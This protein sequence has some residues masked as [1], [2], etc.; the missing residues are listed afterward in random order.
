MLHQTKL[1]NNLPFNIRAIELFYRRDS[2]LL[3]GTNNCS[4]WVRPSVVDALQSVEHKSN[5]T[6]TLS[7]M[8]E[9]E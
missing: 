2:Q 1:R 8:A 9:L 3:T 4:L 5:S 7:K 6:V